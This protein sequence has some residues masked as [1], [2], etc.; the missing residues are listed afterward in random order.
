MSRSST[1]NRGRTEGS[2]R[3]TLGSSRLGIN[4]R[5]AVSLR[6]A[7]GL[8]EICQL[9]ACF[10]QLLLETIIQILGVFVFRVDIDPFSTNG[11]HLLSSSAARGRDLAVG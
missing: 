4:S 10:D 9:F 8:E 1:S 7:C 11:D 3:A 6:R 2:G 5:Q